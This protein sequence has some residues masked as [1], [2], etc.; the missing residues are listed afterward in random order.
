M[1]R[2]KVVGQVWGTRMDARLRG[3]TLLLVAAEDAAGAPTGEVVV[4]RDQL[5]ARRGETVLVAFGSGA[6]NAIL[7][8]ASANRGVLAEAAVVEIVDGTDA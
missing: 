1:I 3:A 7:P 8:G 5:D 6:R 2:G 4:A